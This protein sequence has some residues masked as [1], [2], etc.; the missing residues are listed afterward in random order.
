VAPFPTAVRGCRL[1]QDGGAV[2]RDLPAS[3]KAES[4][5]KGNSQPCVDKGGACSLISPV[6][7]CR[8]TE[9]RSPEP[10][11]RASLVP[12]D[13]AGRPHEPWQF[14]SPICPVRGR[15]GPEAGTEPIVAGQAGGLTGVGLSLAAI[16]ER[17]TRRWRAEWNGDTDAILDAARA[18][19][20]AGGIQPTKGDVEV[21][22]E[23]RR[24]SYLTIDEAEDRLRHSDTPQT[25]IVRCGPLGGA[26]IIVSL[27]LDDACVDGE[28]TDPDVLDRV[29]YPAV[30]VL[31]QDGTVQTN[32][33]W[34]T[35]TERMFAEMQDQEERTGIKA[36]LNANQGTTAAIAGAVGAVVGTL[37]L[38][39]TLGLI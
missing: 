22:W 11:G 5:V 13:T 8:S 39:R 2:A 26:S 1:T 29:F 30:N 20:G 17:P 37:T 33:K 15:N 16:M 27:H 32:G 28:G 25:V 4:R 24:E 10:Q 21:E 9:H 34:L 38:L 31:K 14:L 19:I 6:G 3:S 18:A 23:N 35:A 7:M 36:W 12:W